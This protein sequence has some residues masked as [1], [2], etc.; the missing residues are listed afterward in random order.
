MDRL[1]WQGFLDNCTRKSYRWTLLPICLVFYKLCLFNLCQ[2]FKPIFYQKLPIWYLNIML[3]KRGYFDTLWR[4]VEWIDNWSFSWGYEYEKRGTEV[5]A[6]H[7]LSHLPSDH[8]FPHW[9]KG[10][11]PTNKLRTCSL[12]LFLL[13]R[14]QRTALPSSILPQKPSTKQKGKHILPQDYF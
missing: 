1:S 6:I 14:M 8:R 9:K 12:R 11:L 5:L 10:R 3:K 7:L 4:C 2:S 13:T